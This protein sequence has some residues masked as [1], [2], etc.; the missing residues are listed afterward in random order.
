MTKTN[1]YPEDWIGTRLGDAFDID[2]GKMLSPEASVG[3]H[4]KPYLANR[5]VQWNRFELA[6]LGYMNFSMTE[7]QR[8]RLVPG[9]LLV[10]E[11]GEIGR[12]AMWGGE[13]PECYFQKAIHRLRPRADPIID[14][15]FLLHYMKFAIDNNLFPGLISQT[16]IAH[17]TREKLTLLE[18]EH[19]VQA[20]EQRRIAAVL[21]T[22]DGRIQSSM[23]LM[24]KLEELRLSSIRESMEPGLACFRE[25][26]ASELHSGFRR[27]VG[28]WK[29]VPLGSVL[30]SIDA[31]HSPD[32]EDT[33]A[34]PGQWGVLKVSAVGNGT[35]HPEENKVVH[36]RALCSPAIC[37]RPGDLLMTRANTTQL[38]GL[39]CLAEATPPHLMLSDKTLRLRVSH[40]YAT[41]RYV[42]I[43]LEVDEIRRQIE[44]EATGTSGSMKNISQQAIRRLMIPFGNADDIERVT[45]VDA[46]FRAQLDSMRS[47]VKRLQAL[48]HGLMDDLLTGRVRVTGA[49]MERV[50]AG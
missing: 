47:E 7:R 28:S 29:L 20:Q 27:N 24:A 2:L 17:L 14:P 43:V 10:C 8:F 26:E 3:K 35:F 11:G 42:H 21:D 48:K 33:P 40:P 19:P 34:G 18:V 4:L 38:V 31:G 30:A 15:R 5:N 50:G 25:V 49:E 41:T 1:R 39:S 32:L 36:N 12:T 23:R 13:L 9:D 44:I 45:N 46:L 16:S 22:L 6:N 37:V